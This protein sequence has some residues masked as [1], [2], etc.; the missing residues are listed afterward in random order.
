M[1]VQKPQALEVIKTYQSKSYFLTRREEFTIECRDL[2]TNDTFSQTRSFLIRKKPGFESITAKGD[3]HFRQR[4][5]DERKK[6][7]RTI[8]YDV[9]GRS[10]D[11]IFLFKQNSKNSI[12]VY[13]QLKDDFY[14]HIIK[15]VSVL[16]RVVFT[17][18]KIVFSNGAILRWDDFATE[19]LYIVGNY[20]VSFEKNRLKIS[21]L[22]KNT[23]QDSLEIIVIRSNRQLTGYYLDVLFNGLNNK[24]DNI[25][26]LLGRIGR[27]HF[28]FYSS[29]QRK[30]HIYRKNPRVAVMVNGHLIIG[31]TIKRN[32]EEC[33]L[34]SVKDLLIYNA[35]SDFI[36]SD[37]YKSDGI[38]YL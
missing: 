15:I 14:M 30:S 27:N 38:I 5:Y 23:Q 11:L 3:P 19:M 35:V 25:D 28:R 26:G 13:G 8:C 16:G 7:F 10:G 17:T 24:Y 9:T 6:R 20:S 18:D 37:I 33:W 4:V 31:K 2:L 21:Y 12:S 22:N 32:D 1:N 36:I 34:L 29:V